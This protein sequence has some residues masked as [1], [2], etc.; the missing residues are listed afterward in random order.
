MNRTIENV[1]NNL[2]EV[3]FYIVVLLFHGCALQFTFDH[4]ELE[5]LIGRGNFCEVFE[6]TEK[7]TKNRF[8]LKVFDRVR[9]GL[10]QDLVSV[11]PT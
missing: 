9:S 11:S 8:A 6:V 5:R 7:G 1:R 2:R 4:F 3:T 10:L